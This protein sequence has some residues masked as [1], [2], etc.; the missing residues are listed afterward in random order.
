MPRERCPLA[1]M[2]L[3]AQFKLVC[4]SKQFVFEASDISQSEKKQEFQGLEIRNR[5]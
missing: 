1:E 3:E 2:R 5:L 4:E